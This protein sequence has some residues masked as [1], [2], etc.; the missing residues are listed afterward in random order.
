MS[1]YLWAFNKEFLLFY[2]VDHIDKFNNEIKNFNFLN[3]Q[4]F[5]A[6]LF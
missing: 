4:K 6:G 1:D 5:L 3:K 2:F